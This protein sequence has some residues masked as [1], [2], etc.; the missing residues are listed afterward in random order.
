MTTPP[1]A[2]TPTFG[3]TPRQFE[4]ACLVA[5]GV[6][7]KTIAAQLDINDDTVNFH[8]DR[9]VV[10]WHLDPTK[11]AKTQIALRLARLQSAA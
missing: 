6:I 5:D 4:V 9:I 2:S 11:E 1:T 7:V 10:A 8:I 3:L